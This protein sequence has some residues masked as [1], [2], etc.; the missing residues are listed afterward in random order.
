M[1]LSGIKVFKVINYKLT[2]DEN[3]DDKGEAKSET[4]YNLKE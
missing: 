3:N 2:N 4:I 1:M